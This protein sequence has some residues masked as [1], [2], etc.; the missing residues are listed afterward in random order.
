MP[1]SAGIVP[2]IPAA[3]P[4]VRADAVPTATQADRAAEGGHGRRT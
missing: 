4:H 3:V 1:V 2:L